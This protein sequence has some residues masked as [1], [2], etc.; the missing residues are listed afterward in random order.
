MTLERYT[1]AGG[2][3][4]VRLLEC[5]LCDES[6]GPDTGRRRTRYSG[7]AAHLRE[8]GAFYEAMG[9]D[10]E[11]PLPATRTTSVEIHP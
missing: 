11:A 7:A 4:V 10:P 9:V 1:D 6:I 8:C 3:A 5:P 2:T